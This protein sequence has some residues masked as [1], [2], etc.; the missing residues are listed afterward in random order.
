MKNTNENVNQKVKLDDVANE[1]GVS[2]TTVSR[3]LNNR[4]Y[5]SEKTRK[6]VNEAM[7][8]LNYHPNEIARS[9]FIN[10]TFIIGLIFP[11]TNNPFYGQLIFHLENISEALG[12]K[13]LLCNSEGREDKEK[14][15]LEMLQR[16][17]V[18]GII[19]GSHN[20]GILEYD[21]PQLPLVGIDRYLSE[22]TP[23]VSSDNYD[24]GKKAT[25]LLID[26]GCKKIIH[27]NGSPSLETPANLRREAYEDVMK[28]NEYYP[29]SYVIGEN[30][31]ET[32]FN[33][34]PNIDGIFASDD[35]IASSVMK[36]AKRR[37]INIPADLKVIGYDGSEITRM[38]LPELST[39]QQPVKEIADLAVQLL[40]KQINGET[41]SKIEWKLPVK[42][43]E[44]ETT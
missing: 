23:V 14:S 34:N 10:K 28:E 30:V 41:E 36:E 40:L 3:V 35:L 27:I 22:N 7:E 19:A 5:I 25:Q 31:I 1:A 39:I 26:K 16:H 21:N 4:G 44:S 38:L 17:Q 42:L 8:L 20:R 11:T 2:K 6:K 24:G 43:I 9:L 33:E 32:I 29:Q 12:Y 15:Y 37:N 18:D 13:V